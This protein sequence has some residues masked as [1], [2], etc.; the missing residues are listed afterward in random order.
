MTHPA[1]VHV[2]QF[3]EHE[4]L[5]PHLA[6]VSRPFHGLAHALVDEHQLDGPELTVALRKLLEAKDAAVRT[7]LGSVDAYVAA[8]DAAA[9]RVT[10]ALRSTAEPRTPVLH[11]VAPD[12]ARAREF[13]VSSPQSKAFQRV[14]Y[15]TP[16]A[17]M[18]RGTVELHGRDTVLFLDDALGQPSES[19][20]AF[21]KRIVAWLLDAA[22][23]G[24]FPTVRTEDGNALEAILWEGGFLITASADSAATRGPDREK[25]AAENGE[26][27]FPGA[28]DAG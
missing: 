16:E 14:I 4:H 3:F 25:N 10:D 21:G 1:S 23:R 12:N 6:A 13:D 18:A 5:P 11:I 22:R 27:G 7:R 28:P 24:Q 20:V 19:V 26:S 8:S 2:L 9:S 17:I 15:E